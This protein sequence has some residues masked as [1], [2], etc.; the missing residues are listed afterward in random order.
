MNKN[1]RVLL[2][3]SGGVDSSAAALVLKKRGFEVIGGTM[4]LLEGENGLNGV[5][6]AKAAAERMGI[7][8][9]VFDFRKKFANEVI[10][11]F[12]NEYLSGLTPNPCV[13]CNR[14]LKFSAMMEEADRLDCR[15]IAT[16]HYAR[17][18]YDED[19]KAYLLKKAVC[20][21]EI[22]PKDQSYVLY[23]LTQEQL[24][25]VIFPLGSIAKEEVRR[26]A[27]ESGLNNSKK[28]DSQDICFVPDGNYAEFIEKYTG[29]KPQKGRV[30]D[31]NG[32]TVGEH[33]GMIAYTVGQRKGLGIAFGKPMYVIDKNAR[34]NTVTVGENSDL[35]SE[36]LIASD[37]N[38]TAGY[39]GEKEISCFAKTRYG[40]KEAPCRAV[41]LSPNTVRVLFEQPQRAVAKGQRVVFYDKDIVLGGGVITDVL[42]TT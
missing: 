20:G 19:K 31:K 18:E 29:I 13:D 22:N 21:G 27:E 5:N 15:Y 6:D 32:N 39:F 41:P 10:A 26:L 28:S 37:V 40:Q 38:R 2:A 17:V 36:G 16:G 23:N 9:Y 30:T 8:H 3:M 33:G 34:D 42:K 4:L 25:R 7:P 24:K 14:F 12:N 35:F 11:R 1:S